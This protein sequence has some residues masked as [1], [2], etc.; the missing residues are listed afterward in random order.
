MPETT[1]IASRQG[2][3]TE[4]VPAV[5]SALGDTVVATHV[6]D[7]PEHNQYH[8]SEGLLEAVVDT[9]DRTG[10]TRIVVDGHLHPGQAVDFRARMPTVAVRDRRQVVYERLARANPVARTK[11]ELERTRIA[12]RAAQ[13]QQRTGQTQSPDGT[14]GRVADFEQQCETLRSDLVD[15]RQTAHRRVETEHTYAD[16]RIV[17]LSRT[18]RPA[19][20][21]RRT[22]RDDKQT[23]HEPAV[24][25][26]EPA[27]PETVRTQLGPRDVAVTDIPGV[28]WDDGIPE[29]FRTVVPGTV[30][31]LERADVVL[32][33]QLAT[34]RFVEHAAEQFDASPVLVESAERDALV[35]ALEGVLPTIR[36]AVTLPYSDD[37]QAAVSWL[38]DRSSVENITYDDHIEIAATVPQ[39]AANEVTRRLEAAGG[40]VEHP[41]DDA[42]DSS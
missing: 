39:T 6:T 40:Q 9:V 29:W 18:G 22:L 4:W 7:A 21:S 36:L 12:L 27:R 23:P 28:C 1:V 13:Q 15:R 26:L 11:A 10:C 38:Y 8:L 34:T 35:A 42:D 32:N 19:A 37:A 20:L 3:V 33:G 2:S 41:V 14:S 31:V 24:D 30:A 16:T 17:I 5:V 25:G